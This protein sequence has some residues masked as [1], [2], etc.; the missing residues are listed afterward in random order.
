MNRGRMFLGNF[1]N[2]KFLIQEIVVGDDSLSETSA[3][4]DM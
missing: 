4:L 3:F 1:T 2:E